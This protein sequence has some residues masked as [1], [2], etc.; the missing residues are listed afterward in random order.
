MEN[1]F[2]TLNQE[3]QYRFLNLQDDESITGLPPDSR[4]HQLEGIIIC[5]AEGYLLLCKKISVC[6][7][8]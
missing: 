1:Q 8:N 3:S 6:F 4:L 2:G 5:E 7:R